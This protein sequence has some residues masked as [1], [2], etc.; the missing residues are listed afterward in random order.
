MKSLTFKV[1]EH[2]IY[3]IQYYPSLILVYWL[4]EGFLKKQKFIG[5]SLK[6]I[7]TLLKG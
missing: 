5:Y 4:E 2:K 1:N 6:E 7:K 3:N